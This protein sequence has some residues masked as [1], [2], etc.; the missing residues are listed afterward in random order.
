MKMEIRLTSDEV[1][2]IVKKYSETL[3]SGYLTDK[4]EVEIR[5]GYSAFTVTITEKE[6]IVD[7]KRQEE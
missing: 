2:E 1:D 3:L 5:G 7:D 6:E 4:H